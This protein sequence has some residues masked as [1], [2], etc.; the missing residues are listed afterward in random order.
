MVYAQIK[1]IKGTAMRFIKMATSLLS[2]LALLYV[3]TAT[4]DEELTV[5]ITKPPLSIEQWYKPANKRQVWLHT[6]FRL[7]R[8]IQAMDEYAAFKDRERLANWSEK[9]VKDYKS[10]GE[11]VPEWADVL[12]VEWANRLLNAAKKGDFDG[13]GTAQRKIGK[14]CSGCHKEYRAV[15]AAL[16]RGADFSEVV[17]EDG[18]TME[19]RSFK[20]SMVGLSSAM[21]R[22]KI[23][24]TDNRF[25][26]AHS[27]HELMTQRLEDLS[28]S[29]SA[30][31][32]TDRQKEYLM[33]EENMAKVNKLGE[34]I[35]VKDTKESQR[36]LGSVAVEICATCHSI[37]RTLSDLSGF[38][39]K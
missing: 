10:I 24:I 32:K 2:I 38:I 7:R 5:N 22:I 20:K 17:V 27:S 30:C 36:T 9:F 19:E 14:S 12:E 33:G 4:A 3:S 25:D 15:T 34:L 8:E 18:E 28:S 35:K 39:D 1:L 21:N 23:A 26:V 11:M 31:H 16:Y 37:H 13:V 29:C 6:M